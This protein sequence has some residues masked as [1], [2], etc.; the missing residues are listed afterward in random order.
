M[1]DVAKH[2]LYA[3]NMDYAEVWKRKTLWLES[4]L[5]QT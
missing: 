2:E 3:Q 1:V 5:C 4:E